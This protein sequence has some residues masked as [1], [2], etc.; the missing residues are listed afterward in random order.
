MTAVPLSAE[1]IVM[2]SQ[3]VFMVLAALVTATPATIAERAAPKSP[4][5]FSVVR[6]SAP[7]T[8]PARPSPRLDP[9][10][11]EKDS[12]PPVEITGPQR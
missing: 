8:V 7:Q 2:A 6:I 3:N 12:L 5:P 10:R 1:R 11:T 4:A 9:S